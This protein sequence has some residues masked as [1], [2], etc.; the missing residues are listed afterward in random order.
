MGK[1]GELA[2]KLWKLQSIL[3]LLRRRG[4][5]GDG[6]KMG[7]ET[8]WARPNLFRTFFPLWP[9]PGCR[10]GCV[11]L[12]PR[13]LFSV[14]LVAVIGHCSFSAFVVPSLVRNN[15]WSCNALFLSQGPGEKVSTFPSLSITVWVRSGVIKTRSWRHF[16]VAIITGIRPW[17]SQQ[18]DPKFTGMVGKWCPCP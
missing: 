1:L 16:M 5:W 8:R 2:S 9:C 12:N 15:W 11:G 17:D 6:L 4:C 18:R 3:F 10:I 14:V 13:L 7:G